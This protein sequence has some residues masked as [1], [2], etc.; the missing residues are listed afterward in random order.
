MQQRVDGTMPQRT[1]FRIQ[2]I[3][4]SLVSYE[5]L[6][7]EADKHYAVVTIVCGEAFDDGALDET[8]LHWACTQQQGGAWEGPP[9]GWTTEP[10]SS[11]DAGKCGFRD[12]TNGFDRCQNTWCFHACNFQC[13]TVVKTYSSSRDVLRVSQLSRARCDHNHLP[14]RGLCSAR[15]LQGGQRPAL[16][17]AT[18]YCTPSTFILLTPGDPQQ[19][20]LRVVQ[21]LVF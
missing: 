18:D 4:G 11:L 10:D 3:D 17:S 9:P 1:T 21:R 12:C 7:Q 15:L 13:M 20:N 5:S 14:H 2:S 19:H 8:S 6:S 16:S